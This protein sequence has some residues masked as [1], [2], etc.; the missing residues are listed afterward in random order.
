MFSNSVR[1]NVLLGAAEHP[2]LSP[3]EVLEQALDVAQAGFAHTL[4]Q[5]VDTLIGEE[6]LS[7]SGRQRQRIAMARAIA[8]KPAVLALDDPLSALDVNTEERVSM[9]LRKVL[10]NRRNPPPPPQM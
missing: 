1:E 9:R 6:G 10:E 3:V 7:L 2:G 5:G 8:A 4:P